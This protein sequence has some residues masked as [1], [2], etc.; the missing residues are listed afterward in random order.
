METK[1]NSKKVHD[2]KILFGSH[3]IFQFFLRSIRRLQICKIPKFQI[4]TLKHVMRVF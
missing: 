4:G 2:D 1:L 3:G